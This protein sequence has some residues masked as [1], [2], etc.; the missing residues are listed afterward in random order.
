V[1]AYANSSSMLAWYYSLLAVSKALDSTS[2]NCCI[3]LVH[4][5]ICMMH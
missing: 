2:L 5:S 3:S 4:S 1:N